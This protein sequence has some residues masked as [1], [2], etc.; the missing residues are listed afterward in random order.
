MPIKIQTS[1]TGQTGIT[2][3][4]RVNGPSGQIIPTTGSV[5]AVGTNSS[6]TGTITFT[7]DGDGKGY[8]MTGATTFD[9]MS[10][11]T[12]ALD[13]SISTSIASSTV[14][15]VWAD[16]NGGATTTGAYILNFPTN[17]AAVN[18]NN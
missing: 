18:Y 4:V 2:S 16:I 17:A 5:A 13:Q 12:L 10:D 9:I 14:D 8:K 11:V 6:A 3:V 15:F 1:A 7:G